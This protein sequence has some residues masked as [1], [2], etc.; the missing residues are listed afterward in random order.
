MTEEPKAGK[1][2]RKKPKPSEKF[3][4]VQCE[5][6]TFMEDPK[7]QYVTER[8]FNEGKNCTITKRRQKA[9]HPSTIYP[10][11]GKPEHVDTI[12]LYEKK[13]KEGW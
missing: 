8:R 12:V 9:E 13:P 7:G 5:R 1:K 6:W 3:W 10:P 2:P 11:R 4:Q